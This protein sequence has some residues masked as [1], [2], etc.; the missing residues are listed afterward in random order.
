MTTHLGYSPSEDAF[1]IDARTRFDNASTRTPQAFVDLVSDWQKGSAV[2]WAGPL[3]PQQVG[4]RDVYIVATSHPAAV[5]PDCHV[6]KVAP[7]NAAPSST[8]WGPCSAGGSWDDADHKAVAAHEIGHLMGLADEYHY[9]TMSGAWVNDNP[10]P[11]WKPQSVMAQ[12]WGWVAGLPEHVTKVMSFYQVPFLPRRFRLGRFLRRVF[13]KPERAPR[14]SDFQDIPFQSGVCA[15][16]TGSQP[17]MSMTVE[18]ILA[19]IDKGQPHE[20]AQGV[21]ALIAKGAAAVPDLVAALQAASAL[22]RWAAAAALGRLRTPSAVDPLLLV[23][24]DTVEGVR[25]AAAES[26]L[27]LQSAAGM[28]TLLDALASPGMMIAHPPL[29]SRMF[30]RKVLRHATGQDFGPRE[31]A[32]PGDVKAAKERWDRWWRDNQ[33]T[34]QP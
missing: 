33:A 12:T 22:R 4:G 31:P 32:T 5:F 17:M 27:R 2:I 30:A 29:L 19:S 21:E 6:V 24:G 16:G 10:Q 3:P 14:L 28:G 15:T 9:D 11:S 18:Q 1:L 7:E 26:L 34:F 20:M 25:L 23:L 8:S 13:R